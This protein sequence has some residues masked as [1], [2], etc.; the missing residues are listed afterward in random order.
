MPSRPIL[1]SATGQKPQR[2]AV[3]FDPPVVDIVRRHRALDRQQRRNLVVLQDH[4]AVGIDDEADV[5][6]TVLPFLMARLGLRHDVDVPLARELADLVGFG[7]GYVDAAGA[8]IIGVV[9]IKHF[10]VESHRSAPRGSP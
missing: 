2:A 8:R 9:D 6:E 4:L 3:F 10:V 5:E 7:T 1:V